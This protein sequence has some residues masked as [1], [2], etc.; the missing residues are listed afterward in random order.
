[1]AVKLSSVAIAVASA[2]TLAACGGGGGGGGGSSTSTTPNATPASVDVTVTPS[3]GQFSTGCSVELRKGSGEV[4]GSASIGANGTAIIKVTGYTDAVIATVK[5]ASGCTY[6]DEASGTDKPFG[7]DK[8]LSA[9][10]PSVDQQVGINV[11]THIAATKVLDTGG[12]ALAAGQTADTIKLENTTVGNIFQVTRITTPPTLLNKDSGKVLDD[13]EAGKLAAKLAALAQVASALA[14]PVSIADLATALADDLKDGTLDS[15]DSAKLKAG[16]AAAVTRYAKPEYKGSL[17]DEVAKTTVETD[18]NKAKTQAQ[19]VLAAGTSLDQAKQIFADLRNSILSISNENG[20]GSLDQQNALLKSDFQNGVYATKLID[21]LSL[22]VESATLI[23]VE[24][25]ATSKQNDTGSCAVSTYP[26]VVCLMRVPGADRGYRVTMRPSLNGATVSWEVTHTRN[27]NTGVSTP[28]SGMTGTMRRELSGKNILTGNFYPMTSDGAYTT[29]DAN[30]TYSGSKGSQLWSGSGELN[31]LKADGS[32][33]TLK[34][35]ISDFAADEAKKTARLVGTLVGPHHRFEG[36]LEVADLTTSLD[37]VAEPK[38]A[39]F[40]GSFYNVSNPA[41]P[42]KFL[43][44]RVNVTQD[45]STY[46]AALPESTSN[47]VKLTVGFSGTAYKAADVPGIGLNL[48]VSNTDGYTSQKGE[49]TL[50]GLGSL[51]LTGKATQVAGGFNWEIKNTNGITVTY[52]AGAKSGTVKNAD[53]T[54]LGTISS[55]RVSFI[56]NTYTSLI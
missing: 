44:G 21:H 35:G 54:L 4:L 2:F 29:V 16:L 40:I 42:F 14:T 13:S 56:D 19:N 46:S 23:Y 39:K 1:M 37:G 8:K 36:S 31:T 32:T 38:T 49:F 3:L 41:S 22:M 45:T 33:S 50:T 43:D 48:S 10:L 47:F 52:V 17:D 51:S 34:V 18:S 55:Q 15:V 5:G 27:L 6:F 30:F 11:L 20:T 9:V 7:A 28:V 24:Q 12:S 25:S 53:G 26:E